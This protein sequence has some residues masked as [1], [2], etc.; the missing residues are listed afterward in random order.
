MAGLLGLRSTPF[1]HKQPLRSGGMSRG[2]TGA[3][4]ATER[5]RMKDEQV[6]ELVQKMQSWESLWSW[7]EYSNLH[8]GRGSGEVRL[9]L[10]MDL[11]CPEVPMPVSACAMYH[12]LSNKERVKNRPVQQSTLATVYG[13]PAWIRRQEQGAKDGQ[14]RDR[15]RFNIGGGWEQDGPE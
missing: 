3:T 10:G 6:E 2:A 14:E 9:G 15:R 8:I 5:R 13:D 11:L 12:L 7:G 4:G 1:E